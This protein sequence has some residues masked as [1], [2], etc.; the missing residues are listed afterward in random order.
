[1]SGG[2]K[3]AISS[4]EM[5]RARKDGEEIVFTFLAQPAPGLVKKGKGFPK[6]LIA[7]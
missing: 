1:M 5:A 7:A 3:R 2:S 6:G 4:S